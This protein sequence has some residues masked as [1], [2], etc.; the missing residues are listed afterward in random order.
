M[1]KFEKAMELNIVTVWYLEQKLAKERPSSW[2]S[3]RTIL[4]WNIQL[5]YLDSCVNTLEIL[6]WPRLLF[7]E[8]ET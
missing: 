5:K 4:T 6:Y 2:R 1:K 3:H 8:V 7:I